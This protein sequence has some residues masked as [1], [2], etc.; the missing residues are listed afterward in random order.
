MTGAIVRRTYLAHLQAKS[1]TAE[2]GLLSEL[3]HGVTTLE[4][5]GFHHLERLCGSQLSQGGASTHL[6]GPLLRLLPCQFHAFLRPQILR[7]HG[8]AQH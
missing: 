8:L 1:H 7:R 4:Q 2:V 3:G 6:R 5:A